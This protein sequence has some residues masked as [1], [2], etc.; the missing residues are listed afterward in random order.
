LEILIEVFPEIKRQIPEVELDIYGGLEGYKNSNP[1]DNEKQNELRNKAKQ[2]T[3]INLKR[4]VNQ[5]ELAEG[6][7]EAKVLAYPN[8]FHETGCIVAVEA[9]VA[10]CYVVSSDIGV[11]PEIV[12]EGALVRG[13]PFSKEYKEKFIEYCVKALNS[14]DFSAQIKARKRIMNAFSWQT[15]ANQW[16]EHLKNIT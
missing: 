14:D 6:Y 7:Y 3:G 2:I 16:K 15:I 9:Q 1:K 10:G 11:L 5:K 12:K 8:T 4:A 13:I